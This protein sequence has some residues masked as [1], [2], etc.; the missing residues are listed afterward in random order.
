MSSEP[1]PNSADADLFQEMHM[2]GDNEVQSTVK[3]S[4]PQSAFVQ[5]CI[6][7]PS[8]VPG[9]AGLP[10][11]DARSQV[12]IEWRTFNVN[13]APMVFNNAEN[14]TALMP[15]SELK[16][17]DYAFLHTNGARVLSIP[18]VTNPFDGY[19][20]SQDFNNVKVCT[21]YNFSNWYKD[22][23]LSRT[24][25]KSTTHTLNATAFNNTGIVAGNQFNPAILFSGKLLQFAETQHSNFIQYVKDGVARGFISRS[26]HNQDVLKYKSF[27]KFIRECISEHT[28]NSF[29]LN[30][31][32]DT[33]IQVINFSNTTTDQAVPTNDQI[34]QQSLR[35]YGGKALEGAFS[36]QRLNTI[37]PE[38]LSASNTSGVGNTYPGLYQCYYYLSF[39]DGSTHF[40]PFSDNCPVGT[41][42]DKLPIL[43]DTLW[44]KDMTFSWVRFSGLS[45]NP[46]TTSSTQLMITKQFL[47]LEVQPSVASPWAGM[48]K[49]GPKPDLTSMQ[50]LMDAFFELKDILPARYNFWGMLGK[51]ASQGLQTFGSSIIDNLM[52]GGSDKKGKN[53]EAKAKSKNANKTNTSKK[54]DK[55]ENKEN[56]LQAEVEKLRKQV[57]SMRIKSSNKQQQPGKRKQNNQR[58][59]R[60]RLPRAKRTIIPPG[61]NNQNTV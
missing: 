33:L 3:P 15:T 57:A 29:E 38:W 61:Q 43:Y 27:P 39:Q 48:V 7:P 36:I 45:I 56:N 25:Y 28:G 31:D 17:F 8:A 22:A 23:N 37:S 30:L 53:N 13:N 55:L 42:A 21:Q 2:H 11:N 9:Y 10:T 1:V 35:S 52:K 50:A 60:T 49:L 16:Q 24:A 44:T 46:N 47:G 19:R 6:H 4:N 40:V 26:I 34:L 51:I 20:F 12:C 5:K 18:F 59:P 41:P 32:P 54:V 14:V 58:Q